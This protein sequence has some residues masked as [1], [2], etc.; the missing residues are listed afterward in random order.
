MNLN[1]L[2]EI[3]KRWAKGE[4]LEFPVITPYKP[5]RNWHRKQTFKRLEKEELSTFY[6]L[7]KGKG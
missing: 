1:E 5:F 6:S 7:A 4:D 3:T 2:Q